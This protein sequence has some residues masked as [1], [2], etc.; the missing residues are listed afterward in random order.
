MKTLK[1]IRFILRLIN[2]SNATHQYLGWLNSQVSHFIL[3]KPASIE[4]LSEYIREQMKDENV[5]FYGIYTAESELHIGNIKFTLIP[6]QP[7]CAEMGI[8]IGEPTWH[9]RGV[10]KEVIECFSQQAKT[11]LGINKILLSVDAANVAAVSAYEKIG[12]V[13]LNDGR[14]DNG[15]NMIWEF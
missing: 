1:S 7:N 4:D 8:L 2:E 15:L 12:F 6:E 13:T 10:A 14:K 11:Q 3:N 5:Y 9:G